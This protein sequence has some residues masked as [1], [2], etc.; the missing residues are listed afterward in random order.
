MIFSGGFFGGSF[1]GS[2]R[3]AKDDARKK[4]P[5]IKP[6]PLFRKRK[7]PQPVEE[8]RLEVRPEIRLEAREELKSFPRISLVELAGSL[9]REKPRQAM[10]ARARVL[11]DEINEIIVPRELEKKQAR[12]APQFYAERK[13]RRKNARLPF[14]ARSHRRIALRLMRRK[15]QRSARA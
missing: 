2:N 10:R 1:F 4:Y 15:A 7:K 11:R 6:Y 9:L 12:F 3:Q 14:W 8:I 5:P 13:K